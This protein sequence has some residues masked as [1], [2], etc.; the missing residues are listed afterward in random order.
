MTRIHKHQSWEPTW[1]NKCLSRNTAALSLIAASAAWVAMVVARRVTNSNQQ[2][3]CAVSA[4][5]T[6]EIEIK[7]VQQVK[8]SVAI[9]SSFFGLNN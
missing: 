8:H 4:H 3:L 6:I 2:Q 1:S 7:R 9:V 5:K